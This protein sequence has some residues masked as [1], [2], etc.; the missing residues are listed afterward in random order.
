MELA[1]NQAVGDV[2]EEIAELLELK[3]ESSF[4]IRAYENA[5]RT[6]RHLST[7]I[8]E[9]SDAGALRSVPGVGEALALKIVEYLESGQMSY[10][11]SLRSEFP[12]GVRQL[13]GI[14]G[15]GP[16]MAAR[17]Y[18]ELGIE[19]V[20]SLQLAAEDGRLAALPR[21]GQKTAENVLKAIERS[22]Q[23]ESKR[24]PIGDVL[25]YVN[26][27]MQ[28]LAGHDYVRNLTVAGSLRRFRETIKDVDVIATSK[29]PERAFELFLGLPG[30]R[31]VIARGPTKLS[32]ITDRGVQIDFRIVPDEA[33]GSLL[34]HFTGSKAHNVQLREYALKRGQSLSEYGIVDAETA[35]RTSFGDEASFYAALDLPWIAPE[36]REGTGE[37]DAARAGRLPAL[38]T[39]EDIRG[40]LHVHTNWSDGTASID[41]MISA[42]VARGYEYVAITD[43]S[44]SRGGNPGGLSI[45]R[46]AQQRQALDDAQ[47]SFPGIRILHGTE[48]DIKNDGSLDFPDDVLER[49]D[50]VVASIHSTFSMGIDQMTARML[51]V[52]RNPNVDAIGHPTGRILGRRPPYELDMEAVFAAAAETGTALEINSFPQRLD[53]R[54]SYV[55]RAIELGIKIVVDTDAHSIAELN[56][57]DFGIA[58]ARR[59]WAQAANIVNTHPLH[60]VLGRKR[61]RANGSA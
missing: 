23:Q 60:E 48:V 36:I 25:P 31:E 6:I 61:V 26:M 53:L 54:D 45:E 35:E 19:T 29:D 16:K 2:L 49:L 41:D 24:I 57:I 42:A 32:V 12:S 7:D 15:V 9:M 51:A 50:W 59:G 44:P 55:R 52:I 17:A 43:H 30:I 3:G 28:R 22:R 13:M 5:A 1:T 14:P 40:D 20:E 56:Q 58:V 37:L 33:Y 47:R 38:V 8:G 4:R 18:H 10:L 21:L 46:L 39:I 34:Q 27:V 11:E